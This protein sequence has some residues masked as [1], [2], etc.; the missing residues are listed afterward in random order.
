MQ[1]QFNRM[2]ILVNK[3]RVTDQNSLLY[4]NLKGICQDITETGEYI[5]YEHTE[6]AEAHSMWVDKNEKHIQ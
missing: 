6:I 3:C 1:L 2:F 5:S 4:V